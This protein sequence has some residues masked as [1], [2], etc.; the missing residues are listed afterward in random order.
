MSWYKSDASYQ[1]DARTSASLGMLFPPLLLKSG[2]WGVGGAQD[3]KDGLV[4]K[5]TSCSGPGFDSQHK[6]GYPSKAPVVEANTWLQQAPGTSMVQA[7]M[8]IKYSYT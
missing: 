8:W 6:Q 3:W 4:V 7:Y 2:R 5:S 1:S